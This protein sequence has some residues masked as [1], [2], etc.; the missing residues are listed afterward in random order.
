M[1]LG[2]NFYRLQGDVKTWGR[3]GVNCDLEPW[4]GEGRGDDT[5]GKLGDTDAE[6]KAGTA[7]EGTVG[8]FQIVSGWTW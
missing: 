1:A 8:G 2:G 7:R 3:K 6:T 5:E 4:S